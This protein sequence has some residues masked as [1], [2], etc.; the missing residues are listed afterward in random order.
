MLKSLNGRSET[1]TKKNGSET[2]QERGEAEGV[3]QQGP[4]MN[5]KEVLNSLLEVDLYTTTLHQRFSP[6]K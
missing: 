5:L 4:M 3:A 1:D 2:S 6:P